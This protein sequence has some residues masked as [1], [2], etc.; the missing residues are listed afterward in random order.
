MKTDRMQ[1][2]QDFWESFGIS[3]Y[4]ETTVPDD[5]VMPYITYQVQMSSFNE[6]VFNT[7]SV[8]YKGTSWADITSKTLEISDAIGLGGIII[9]CDDGALWIKRGTPFAQRMSD[10]DSL[11]RRMYLNIEVEY[12]V[13]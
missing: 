7:A 8:W 9:P 5:A 2:Y 12:F 10:V 3:A 4:E 1:A 11:V 13:N 6:T